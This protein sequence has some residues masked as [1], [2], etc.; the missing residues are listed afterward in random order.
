MRL[1]ELTNN[2]I[3]YSVNADYHLDIALAL[4]YKSLGQTE[5][6]IQIFLE[7]LSDTS[8]S[9]G[10]FDHLHLGVLYLEKGEYPKA[11]EQL[12]IQEGIN[13]LA[14]NRFYTAIAYKALHDEEKYLSNLAASKTYYQKNQ[15]LFDSYV[16]YVD[17]IYLADIL[18][19]EEYGLHEQIPLSSGYLIR[20]N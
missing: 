1:K 15:K 2:Q 13:D 20:R 5:L 11:I 12:K 4:C 18:E 10:L 19:E 7:K 3:G 14:E 8:Y 9:S 6:A 16:E 17:K